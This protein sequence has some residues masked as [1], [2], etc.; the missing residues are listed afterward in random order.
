MTSSIEQEFNP[1]E[2]LS[3]DQV[4]QMARHYINYWKIEANSWHSRWEFTAISNFELQNEVAEL[5]Q[6]GNDLYEAS[7]VAKC[8]FNYKQQLDN[9]YKKSME[10]NEQ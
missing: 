7:K 2:K 8:A 5:K 4:I 3:R 9:W 6:L 10:K 1:P